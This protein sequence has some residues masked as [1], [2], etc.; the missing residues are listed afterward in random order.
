LNEKYE[1]IADELSNHNL[2]GNSVEE[3]AES[4]GLAYV[5]CGS[6]SQHIEYEPDEVKTGLVA[7]VPDGTSQEATV[8]VLQELAWDTVEKG[9]AKRKESYAREDE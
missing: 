6:K 9:H 5:E 2:S 7:P 8:A 4:I 3:I 1:R